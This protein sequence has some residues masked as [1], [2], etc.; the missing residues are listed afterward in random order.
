MFRFDRLAAIAALTLSFAAAAQIPGK[1]HWPGDQTPVA[2]R[3]VVWVEKPE[4][5]VSYPMYHRHLTF[6]PAGK[7]EA[8]PFD[9]DCFDLNHDIKRNSVHDVV[10]RELSEAGCARRLRAGALAWLHTH[11][12]PKDQDE[13][14]ALY[15]AQMKMSDDAQGKPYMRELDDKTRV[16]VTNDSA[17]EK[18]ANALIDGAWGKTVVRCGDRMWLSTTWLGKCSFV[19]TNVHFSWAR[20]RESRCLSGKVK[21]VYEIVD[22][23]GKAS[24]DPDKKVTKLE[25][26]TNRCGFAYCKVWHNGSES[27]KVVAKT[28]GKWLERVDKAKSSDVKDQLV[29]G[30]LFG[31]RCEIEKTV[32]V[33]PPKRRWF[34]CWR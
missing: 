32:S 25:L 18:D 14:G 16:R 27:A 6:T 28:E 33:S 2:W 13:A 15:L 5:F 20:I 4:G 8:L 11:F 29:F 23:E 21:V 26:E 31:K 3:T 10:V 22:P 9:G 19:W 34:F 17:M 24:F 30:A 1:M 12:A 7:T